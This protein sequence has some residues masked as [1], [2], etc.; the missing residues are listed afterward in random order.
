MEWAHE[1]ATQESSRRGPRQIRRLSPERSQKAGQPRKWPQGWL[2][3]KPQEKNCRAAQCP[4]PTAGATPEKWV[5]A[6]VASI[7][8]RFGY[9]AIGLGTDGIRYSARGLG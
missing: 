9:R 8:A 4:T 1:E 3:Q 2:G 7:R 5:S 6:A